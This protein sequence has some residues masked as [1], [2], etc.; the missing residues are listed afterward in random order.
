MSKFNYCYKQV[1]KSDVS[2]AWIHLHRCVEA[3]ART[4]GETFSCVFN[5]I[6]K[7]FK[8][9][10][11]NP[12]KWPDLTQILQATD[13]LKSERDH[14]LIKLNQLIEKRINEKKKG[15]RISKNKEFNQINGKQQSYKQKKKRPFEWRKQDKANHNHE[16][17]H[18]SLTGVWLNGG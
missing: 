11:Q 7:K 15:I 13:F 5:R 9:E 17:K 10:R 14:F 6:E 16:L 12:H 3:F 1:L 18:Q 4:T 2:H 8:F